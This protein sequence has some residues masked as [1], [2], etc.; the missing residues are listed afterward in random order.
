VSGSLKLIYDYA[1]NSV[2]NSNYSEALVLFGILANIE[3]SK[4][5]AYNNMGV[6]Y[7]LMND[8]VRALEMYS[9]ANMLAECI[10]FKENYLTCLYAKP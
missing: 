5:A 9:K 8:R 6:V 4:A 10:Y 2:K 7:E 1:V 3:S